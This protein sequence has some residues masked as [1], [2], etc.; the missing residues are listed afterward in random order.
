MLP[1][2]RARP[3]SPRVRVPRSVTAA[4]VYDRRVS[5]AAPPVLEGAAGLR[6][7]PSV[8]AD[9]ASLEAI[10]REPAVVCWWDEPDPDDVVEAIAGVD[11]VVQLTVEVAGAIAGAIQFSEEDDPMYRHAGIDVYLGA[12]HH[13][14]GHGTEA[15]RLLARWLL[16]PPPAGAGT[17]G[18]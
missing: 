12:A 2:R 9:A 11:G 10:R 13:G 18:S 14:R 16:A 15:V 3:A 6:L 4:P 8:P 17:T 1:A 7:R 5:E